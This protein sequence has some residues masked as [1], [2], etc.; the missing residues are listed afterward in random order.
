V[1]MQT[2]DER[3]LVRRLRRGDRL[4][5]D[6]FMATYMDRLYQ[7][8]YYRALVNR[9]VAEDITQESLVAALN[10]LERF[11]GRAALYTWLCGIARHKLADYFRRQERFERVRAALAAQS[12]ELPG[13]SELLEREEQRRQII[14]VLRGLP[15]RYQ[16]ALMLKYLDHLSGHDLAA[17]LELSEDA[18][19]SLLARA[20]RAFRR[21]YREQAP[22]SGGS[23]VHESL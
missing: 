2:S 19:E 11:D 22:S 14:A 7:F 4:A 3:D 13:P 5:L 8:V 20:R 1:S 6:A 16:Q 23:T 17:Q 9:Q 18:A 15:P 12:G 21:A 10:G